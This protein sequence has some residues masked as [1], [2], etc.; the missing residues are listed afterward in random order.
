MV[1]CLIMQFLLN[2]LVSVIFS[3]ETTGVSIQI[4]TAKG[5]DCM[6]EKYTSTQKYVFCCERGM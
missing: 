1:E 5:R 3:E 6:Q 4:E 2:I